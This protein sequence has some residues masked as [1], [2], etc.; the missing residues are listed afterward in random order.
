MKQ[1]ELTNLW[2]TGKRGKREG[3]GKGKGEGAKGLV[4]ER[5]PFPVTLFPSFPLPLFLRSKPVPV[6]TR[7]DER[8]DHFGVNKVA[9]K[10]QQLS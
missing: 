2:G 10:L 7:D 9:V 1:D 5:Y 3:W 4:T 6:F 8:L